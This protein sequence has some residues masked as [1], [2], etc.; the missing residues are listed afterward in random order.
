MSE[1]E[2]EKKKPAE[3]DNNEADDAS[4]PSDPAE[5]PTRGSE[6][7]PCVPN[8]STVNPAESKKDSQDHCADPTQSD[9]GSG[10]T[11]PPNSSSGDCDPQDLDKPPTTKVNSTLMDDGSGQ[12]DQ[13]FPDESLE[14][15]RIIQKLGEGGFGEVYHA[16]QTEPVRRD[17][18]IKVIKKGMDTKEVLSR[19]HAERQALAMM[20]HPGIAK[21]F[22]AG[23]TATG[24]PFFVMELV[25]GVPITRFCDLNK[26]TV[27]QRVDLFVEVCH[28]IQH[29]HHKGVIHRDIKPSNIIVTGSGDRPLPIVIDFGVAKATQQQLGQE[30]VVTKLHQVIGTP[31][32]MSPE[33]A[34]S[35]GMDIDTRADVYSLGVV[36]YELLCGSLPL[37]RD[38]PS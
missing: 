25:K 22:D 27:R 32:Y 2:N 6:D 12:Y 33:Q 11:D 31:A 28:A 16:R 35:T 15:Y 17:V 36:L 21:V 29:A 13:L 3:P 8:D 37:G 7:R 19:F 4:P 38:Y 14:G 20:N 30:S 23:T 18:A 26:F 5:L 34:E 9:M 10:A 1:D 24:Q